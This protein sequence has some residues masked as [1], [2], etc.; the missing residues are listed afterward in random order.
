MRDVVE[1]PSRRSHPS[2]SQIE[3]RIARDRRSTANRREGNPTPMIWM[4]A[5]RSR[6]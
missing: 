6:I 2:P 5:E 1:P 3:P 4:A